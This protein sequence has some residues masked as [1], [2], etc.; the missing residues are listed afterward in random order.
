MPRVKPLN[1]NKHNKF[2]IMWERDSVNVNSNIRHGSHYKSENRM[3]V[4]VILEIF[5]RVVLKAHSYFHRPE[6]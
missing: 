1:K 5:L 6:Y 3:A 2:F 4:W